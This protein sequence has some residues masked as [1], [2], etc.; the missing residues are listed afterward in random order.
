[1][2]ATVS[3]KW[4]KAA[5]QAYEM[6]QNGASYEQ[7]VTRLNADHPDFSYTQHEVRM[8]VKHFAERSNLPQPEP[9]PKAAPDP[10][11]KQRAKLVKLMATGRTLKELADKTGATPEWLLGELESTP[12][13]M[14]LF[15]TR[16]DWGDAVYHWT[17]VPR[18]RIEVAPRDWQYHI[19]PESFTQT[20]QFSNKADK[21]RIIPLYDS[22][23]GN[24]LHRAAKFA[25]TLRFILEEPNT[26]GFLG[27][28][29]MENALDDGR[30]MTYEQNERPE[31]QMIELAYQLAPVAHKILAGTPG[32]HEDRT[33]KRSDINPLM[34]VCDMLGIPFFNGPLRLV[35]CWNG[36]MWQLA[37]AHGWGA[38]ATPGGRLNAAKKVTNWR[39]GIHFA[40]TGHSHDPTVKNETVEFYDPALMR[41][42]LRSRWLVIAPSY[43]DY[44]GGYAH[45]AGYAPPGKGGAGLYIYSNGEY[46]ATMTPS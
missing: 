29:N 23:R 28:D 11:E 37:I 27:G 6:R 9:K 15:T 31:S 1:M 38:S 3:A 33:E 5:Q 30:G 45:K 2:A 8:K 32:N 16:N 25:E 35:C 40:V 19:D 21:I 18:R 43:L 46:Q 39:D 36:F 20:V 24:K 41:S 44:Y 17:P 22:H 42:V 13:D 7:I 12:E 10:T 4:R 34:Y 26:Y 14:R